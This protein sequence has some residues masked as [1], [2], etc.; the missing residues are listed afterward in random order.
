MNL[1]QKAKHYKRLYEMAGKMPIDATIIHYDTESLDHYC[2]SG[3]FYRST[4]G[5]VA[6]EEI[7]AIK[8][9]LVRDYHKTLREH[10]EI[11]GNLAHLDIWFKPICGRESDG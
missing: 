6:D 1:R 5:Q 3:I 2:T 10:V 11:K 8:D 9:K 4:I 7:D